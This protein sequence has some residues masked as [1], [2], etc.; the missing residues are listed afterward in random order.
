MIEVVEVC[1]AVFYDTINK[2]EVVHRFV[3]YEVIIAQKDPR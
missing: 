1:A 2:A 3:S